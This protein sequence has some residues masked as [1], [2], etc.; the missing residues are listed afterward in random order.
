MTGRFC[1]KFISI[2]FVTWALLGSPASV[3]AADGTTFEQESLPFLKRY[4]IKC[5]NAEKAK[6]GVNL[7][8]LKSEVALYRYRDRVEDT[9]TQLRQK[10]MPP[11]DAKQP[12]EA[13][14]Q[15][16][17]EYLRFKLDNFDPEKY[18]NPG[19]LP[20]HRLTRT[21]YKNTIRDLVG[22]G[23]EVTENLPGD[24]ATFGF[25]VIGEAQEVSPAHL[26]KYMEA[27][28]YILD[29]LF[30]PPAQIWKL[31]AKDLEYVR[32][33]GVTGDDEKVA[34]PKA[35]PDH[36]IIGEDQVIYHTGGVVLTHK[37]P[38]TGLY[39]F[40]FKTW[41]GKAEEAMRGPTFKV[42]LDAHKVAEFGIPTAGPS[43]VE[44]PTVKFVVREGRHDIKLEMEGMAVNTNA[45][46]QAGQFNRAA[47]STIEI[48]GPI[49][50][51]KEKARE[52]LDSILIARPNGEA[53]NK[54][55]A[56]EAAQTIFQT[57]TARAYRR[58][59]TMEDTEGLMMLFERSQ[60]RGDSFEK[61][62]K[63][64]LKAALV[65]P[66]FLFHILKD[67]STAKAYRLNDYELANRLS[68]FLWSSMPDATLFE[69][70]KN[71]SLNRPEVLS[72]QTLRMLK[73]PKSKSLA[74]NFAPQWLGLGSLF[75]VHR[76]GKFHENNLRER[77]EMLEEVVDFFDYIVRENRPVVEIIN[78]N[79]TFVNKAMADHYGIPDVT[80]RDFR[81]VQLTGGLALK[82]G[83]ILGMTAIHMTTSH[84]KETNP[85]GRGKWVLDILLGTP[86][87]PPPPNVPL[88][89]K[90]EKTGAATLRERLSQH[91]SDPNCAACHAK[92]DPIGFCLENYDSVGNWR[93]D[94]GGKPLDVTTKLVGGRTLS[95]PADLK[96]YLATEKK[97]LFIRNFSS[98]I[99]TYALRRGLNYYDEGT[100]REMKAGLEKDDGR[101]D[102]LVLSI[103]QSYPFQYRQNPLVEAITE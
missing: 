60:K 64:G 54:T 99:L 55:S 52:L 1:N 96:K 100:L 43:K 92:I 86:P 5:H 46:T 45:T 73:D 25:D 35:A 68:Y 47:L 103:V 39:Q 29:R 80:G 75:A 34:F 9:I 33:F 98:R 57:F 85:S 65:S 23:M 13:Q 3:G 87:S 79:Y 2:G 53:G 21:Q 12:E 24:E 62:I 74:Q 6:G 32:Q 26:E 77:E 37:F 70:A 10:E 8:V 101:F 58:P 51:N 15:Q 19:Y 38:T 20:S 30:V 48:T 56:C 83:G 81:K 61:S 71:G 93:D 78:A 82:R 95:G 76:D 69:C 16:I 89:P 94:D 27:A 14:R 28:N 40:K 90:E 63:S 42:K 102:S 88:L 17:A 50:E 72:E 49:V 7:D 91:R 18:K 97:D 84:P 67:Q 36:E 31:A 59:S 44:E 4:C 11:E 41:G 22:V 66:H